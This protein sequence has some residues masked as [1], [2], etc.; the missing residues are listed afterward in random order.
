MIR[1]GSQFMGWHLV[2]ESQF[3]LDILVQCASTALL[4]KYVLREIL[5]KRKQTKKFLLNTKNIS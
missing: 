3:S 1:G 4:H 2:N 5:K